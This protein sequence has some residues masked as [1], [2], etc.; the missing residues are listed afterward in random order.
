[1]EIE[2]IIASRAAE[3]EER[4][5]PFMPEEATW[6]KTVTDAMD[7]SVF[8]GGKR[9]RPILMEA[10]YRMFGG[11]GES[12]TPFMAAIEMIHTYS[13]VHDD[14]PAMDNDEYRRG[15]KTTH[16]V[17]GEAMAILTGDALLNRAYEVVAEAMS[18]EPERY[19]YVRAFAVLAH[20]AGV[21]GMV[22]GQVVDV[23]SE[24]KGQDIE[25]D[26]LDFIYRLKTGALIE[27]SLMIGAILAGAQEEQVRRMEEAG[28]KLGLAFQIQDDILDVISTQ[29]VLGKP[30]GSDGRNEKSTY[31][32][33]EGIEKA[34]DDVRRLS[35]EAVDI[36]DSFDREHAFLR[37]LFLYL[38]HR[39]N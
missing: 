3:I 12:V 23:E 26:K 21:Y 29:E 33:F 13:L 7:Y 4:I 31:V 5:R 14:L 20:K 11:S 10:S 28:T 38:I 34:Q 17:Y 36:L 8:A 22:G 39:K 30:I 1:M 18:R 24:K 37:E 15:K 35:Q 32:T 27:A 6:Q 25:R 19:E 16:A 9:L 2:K